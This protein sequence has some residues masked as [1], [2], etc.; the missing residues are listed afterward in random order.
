MLFEIHHSI[1]EYIKSN[2]EY[3]TVNDIAISIDN[4]ANSIRE[5]KHL[6]TS[7][8]HILDFLSDWNKLN[9]N[10]R[11]I[12][13]K[14]YH[15]YASI[16]YSGLIQQR[17]VL[18]WKAAEENIAEL[19]LPILELK[20]SNFLNKTV[21]LTENMSDTKLFE[22]ITI[23]YL[24]H[25]G[26]N[27]IEL[28]LKRDAG[29]GSQTYIKYDEI[30]NTK[31]DFCICICDSD[32]KYPRD[33]YGET[34]QKLKG[35]VNNSICELQC[36]KVR[37]SE[38]LI[39]KILFETHQSYR[40]KDISNLN[41]HEYYQFIDFKRGL[42]LEKLEKCDKKREFW[43]N[44]LSENNIIINNEIKINRTEKKDDTI[45][46][47]MGDKFLSNMTSLLDDKFVLEIKNK[48]ATKKEL[49]RTNNKIP[50][51]AITQLENQYEICNAPFNHLDSTYYK[52]WE[53]IAQKV[54][55]WC[56]GSHGLNV[57]LY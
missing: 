22:N 55:N 5:G 18:Y 35:V 23:K 49:M 24:Q 6:I 25:K 40:N 28:S 8:I 1:I 20:N 48:I 14:L 7:D 13:N 38:N 37:E 43:D 3:Q 51:Y 36:L 29:G 2:G 33:S 50:D 10:T 57:G 16:S 53:S 41:N 9:K 56:C 12:F 31:E 11:A 46:E 42:S 17:V 39:P 32:R 27:H 4:L 45:I 26:I 15:D 34:Y 21:L 19:Q 54:I 30:V 44:Y 52:L 47:G